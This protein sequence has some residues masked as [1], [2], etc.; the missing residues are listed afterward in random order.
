MVKRQS[1]LQTLIVNFTINGDENRGEM[2]PGAV[3]S[4]P[5]A[6]TI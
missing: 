3:G 4:N 5:A 1:S 2:N 6:D